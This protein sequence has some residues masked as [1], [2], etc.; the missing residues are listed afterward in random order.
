M[1]IYSHDSIT[2]IFKKCSKSSLSHLLVHTMNVVN[3]SVSRNKDIIII[4]LKCKLIG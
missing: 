3:I 1:Y 4:L 2:Y